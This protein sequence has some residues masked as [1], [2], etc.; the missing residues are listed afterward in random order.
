MHT[1]GIMVT[2]LQADD[3]IE[4]WIV[5]QLALGYLLGVKGIVIMRLHHLK[6]FIRCIESLDEHFSFGA[7]SSGTSCYLFEHL[8]STL[9]GAEVGLVKERIGIEH[10]YQAHIVK[11]E[12]F[13]YHLRSDENIAFVVGESIDDI[14]VC[15]FIPRCIQI[16]THHTCLRKE[17]LYLILDTF[18]TEADG[19]ILTSAVRTDSRYR[20]VITAVMTTQFMF[21]HME[22]HRHVALNTT[23]RLTTVDTLYLRGITASVLEEN[24]LLMVCQ[25]FPYTRD[26]RIT[27]MAFHLLALVLLP[28]VYECD[29]RQFNATESLGERHQ[30]VRTF[31]R[32]VIRLYRGCRCSQQHFS[33]MLFRQDNGCRARMI[34]RVRFRLLITRVMLFIYDDQSDIRDGQEDR[35]SWSQDHEVIGDF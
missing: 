28:K 17:R 31:L 14:L 22:R 30:T 35:T 16:H 3:P 19:L 27:K 1:H 29:S 23:R 8:I 9:V 32:Q 12:S 24:D 21:A 20:C 2:Q 33:L 34:T 5:E 15:G 6:H 18:G 11:M 25:T 10:R 7:L 4:W 13:G 26:K